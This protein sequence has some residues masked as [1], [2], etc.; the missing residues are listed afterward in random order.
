MFK[1]VELDAGELGLCIMGSSGD[2]DHHSDDDKDSDYDCDP[3]EVSLVLVGHDIFFV[4]FLL[5]SH[6]NITKPRIRQDMNMMKT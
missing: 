3:F 2:C 4:L 6:T 5:R 1:W